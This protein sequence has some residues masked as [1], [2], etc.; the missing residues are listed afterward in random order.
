MLKAI[1][2]TLCSIAVMTVAGGALAAKPEPW[3]T[4]MDQAQKTA[5][6]EGKDIFVYFTGS[7]WCGWCIKL[8]EEVLSK[9]VFVDYAKK[10]LVLVE[11]DFP[12]DEELISEEQ[13]EHN[14]EWQEVFQPEGFPSIYLTDSNAKSYAMT[15]YEEGGAEKYI[16][17]LQALRDGKQATA[18]LQ[19]QIAKASG[20]ER[21]RLL[22]KLVSNDS[23]IVDDREGKIIEI[24]ELSKG[25]DDALFNKYNAILTSQKIAKDMK[26]IGRDIS[27]EERLEKVLAVFDNYKHLKEGHDLERLLAQLGDSFIGADQ[28]ENGVNFMQSVVADDSYSMGM[29]QSAALFKGIINA[30]TTGGSQ[31]DSLSYYE[32]AISMDPESGPGQR[33]K[34]FKKRMQEEAASNAQ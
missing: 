7:D 25:K 15:G 27:K 4:D 11:L 21:A 8:D 34:S 30:N 6:A 13:L 3:I 28:G 14:E 31:Q 16:A 23:A 22:D 29:R 2:K 26:A 33:A 9:P 18:K 32:H 20:V 19:K 5:K 17:N 1:S 10:N 12:N 24:A